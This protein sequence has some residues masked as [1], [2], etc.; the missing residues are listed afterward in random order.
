MKKYLI[1]LTA[2][3]ICSVTAGFGQKAIDLKF[4][5]PVGAG[6]DYNIDMDMTTSGNVG[7]QEINANN[8][9]NIGY[10]FAVAGDSA[11]WKKMAAT[12]TRIAMNINANGMNINYDSDKP[13][14]TTDMISS[15]FGKI[16]GSMKG[17]KFAFTM[18]KEGKVGSVTGM[19]ELINNMSA[20]GGGASMMQGMTNA[21]SEENFKNNLQQSFGFYPAKP[22]K[23]GDTWTNTTTTNTNGAE[24]TMNN[25]YTLESVSGNMANVKV[26]ST[27]SAPASA[28]IDSMSG[29]TT[30]NMQ[31][32]VKTGVPVSGDLG[33]KMDLTI[34]ANGQS[35]P[36]K[37]DIKMKITGKKS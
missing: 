27:L 31:F 30:G 4:N 35:L 17:G 18:N 22:V 20:A 10:N 16:L 11:D 32:D 25:T 33:T 24:M 23:P 28:S 3:L 36:M 7:G 15:T 12:I 2:F 37:M 19:D 6:F 1:A 14:D 5:L 21:F 9:M 13:V 34:N 8:T 29:I 26:N